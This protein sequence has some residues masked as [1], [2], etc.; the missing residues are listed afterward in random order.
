MASLS[1]ETEKPSEF[2]GRVMRSVDPMMHDLTEDITERAKREIVKRTPRSEG[3]NPPG[4]VHLQDEIHTVRVRKWKGV[5]YRSAVESDKDYA[6]D[7]EYRTRPHW[8]P[9]RNP[10]VRLLRFYGTK[11]GRWIAANRVWHPGTEGQHMFMRGVQATEPQVQVIGE[12]HLEKWASQFDV[13]RP[14]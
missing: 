9:A 6:P 3:P 7:V 12:A 2:F 10:N 14:T 13:A 4:H 5:R 1:W 8:I 11:A